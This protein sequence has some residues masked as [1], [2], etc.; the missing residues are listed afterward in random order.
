MLRSAPDV[1]EDYRE[2]FG[3]YLGPELQNAVISLRQRQTANPTAVQAASANPFKP[4]AVSFAQVRTN[5][6]VHLLLCPLDY[7]VSRSGPSSCHSSAACGWPWLCG[8]SVFHFVRCACTDNF[9][10]VFFFGGVT[11]SVL[12]TGSNDRARIE[13]RFMGTLC[14][15][16]PTTNFDF[17]TLANV[18]RHAVHSLWKRIP[19]S[20]S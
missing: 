19:P 7:C 13:N 9:V 17:V 16:V 8:F 10:K 14:C 11:L 1:L 20:I 3:F 18:K 15:I 6:V 4:T 5:D 2:E 12:Q